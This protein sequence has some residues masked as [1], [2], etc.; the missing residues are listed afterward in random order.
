[1]ESL[2]GQNNEEAK[3]WREHWQFYAKE[4]AGLAHLQERLGYWFRHNSLL[5]E[6]VTH[7]SAVKNL[8]WNERI[9]FLGDAVLNLVISGVLWKRSEHYS[10]GELSRIRSSLVNETRLAE[11][12]RSISLQEVLVVGKSVRNSSPNLN[13]ALLA[14]AIEAVFGAIYVDAGFAAAQQVIEGLFAPYLQQSV[15]QLDKDYKTTLQE[16]AQEHLGEKPV[17]VLVGETGPDHAKE[18]CVAV[19][20][21][22]K[23]IAQGRGISKKQASQAAAQQ[24]LEHLVPELFSGKKKR[25]RL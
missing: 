22:N 11:I 21:Q 18:F 24:A 15:I 5:F 25:T 3:A 10:E 13:N 1:M 8:P 4:F 7:R 14:D 19:E 17:Y 6:A 20:L 2:P 16:W 12:A 9:E 23:A